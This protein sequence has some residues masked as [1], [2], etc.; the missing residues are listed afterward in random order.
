MQATIGRCTGI[1]PE[2]CRPL[3]HGGGLQCRA[4]VGGE[5]DKGRADPDEPD[6]ADVD[7]EGRPHVDDVGEHGENELDDRHDPEP[8]GKDAISRR[9]DREHEQ[10]RTADHGEDRGHGPQCTA[11]H[12]P[13]W[14]D[15]EQGG[16]D[17]EADRDEVIS[18]LRRGKP[19]RVTMTQAAMEPTTTAPPLMMLTR[20]AGAYAARGLLLLQG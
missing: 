4:R 19:A 17:G 1:L 10:E 12:V 5:D 11:E 7:G 8:E 13:E 15:S 9:R 14:G 16:D 2:C 18:P 3:P 6:A 20:I